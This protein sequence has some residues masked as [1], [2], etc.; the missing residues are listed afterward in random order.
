M[1]RPRYSELY[2]YQNTSGSSRSYMKKLFR[3]I[4]ASG[5]DIPFFLKMNMVA[6]ITGKLKTEQESLG[7]VKDAETSSSEFKQFVVT[8]PILAV[9]LKSGSPFRCS[10]DCFAF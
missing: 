1:L 10:I 9:G 8:I 5:N 7:V 3:R 2:E 6:I 4:K